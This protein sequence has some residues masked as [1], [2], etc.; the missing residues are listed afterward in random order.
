MPS[1]MS[2]IMGGC[3]EVGAK[4]GAEIGSEIEKEHPEYMKS[5]TKTAKQ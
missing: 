3:A 5:Q 2:E 4:L 1:L